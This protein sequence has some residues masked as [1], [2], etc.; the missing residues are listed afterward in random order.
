MLSRLVRFRKSAQLTP[1]ALA[2]DEVLNLVRGSN[3]R[4]EAL[5]R[6]LIDR[7]PRLGCVVVE[8]ARKRFDNRVHE[9]HEWL[10]LRIIS[11]SRADAGRLVI[12]T[13]R[14]VRRLAQRQSLTAASDEGSVDDPLVSDEKRSRHAKLETHGLRYGDAIGQQDAIYKR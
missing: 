6:D 13:G 4:P 9:T 10:N 1:G 3:H 5:E 7:G 8:I 12:A 2:R 14:T 11:S